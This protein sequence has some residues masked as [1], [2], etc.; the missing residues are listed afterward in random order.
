MVLK[1][2]PIKSE[3]VDDFF[4]NEK[5]IV[6]GHTLEADLNGDVTKVMGFEGKVMCQ[7]IDICPIFKNCYPGKRA[8][9]AYISEVVLGKQICKSYTLTNWDRR[10][11]LRNQIHYAALDAL[12][13]LKIWDVLKDHEHAKLIPEKKPKEQK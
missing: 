4:S 13:V 1:K 9:L 8:G 3:F 10:P 6:V 7:K 2:N 12:I 11:L 5:N